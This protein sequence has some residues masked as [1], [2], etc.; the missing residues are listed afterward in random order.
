MV[1][2]TEMTSFIF[3]LPMLMTFLV[4][5]LL[6]KYPISISIPTERGMHKNNIISSGGIAILVG[7]ISYILLCLLDG[8]N[9]H[10]ALMHILAFTLVSI[11]GYLDDTRS[12]SKKIRFGA[13]ILISFLIVAETTRLDPFMALAA[14][15]LMVYTINIYN[16]M[17]GIDQLAISQAMIFT[18]SSAF[19]FHDH[20]YNFYFIEFMFS[21]IFISFF[22]IN[23]QKTKIFLGNSGSYLLGLYVA[24]TI[25]SMHEE[26]TNRY[27]ERALISLF[28]LMTIFYVEATYAIIA[29]FLKK[30]FSEATIL[31]SI[32]HVTHAHRTHAYQKLAIKYNSHSKVV[33]LMMA[34]NILWCLPLA[35]IAFKYGYL[36][37]PLMLSYIPYIY[38]CYINKA[39]SE[40]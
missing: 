2:V 34:Y 24:L 20:T 6:I 3:I 13:Q 8:Y 32:R 38:Y 12:L 22:F 15:I 14:I 23:Y 1:S 10:D 40:V 28:I 25:I 37:L 11:I 16:F 33:L 19:I 4:G 26:T 17:D 36:L 31:E 5:Y 35:Y 7:I 9:S 18:I 27:D 29:R 39:G 30:I 21:L